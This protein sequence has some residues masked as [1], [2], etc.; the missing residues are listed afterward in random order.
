MGFLERLFGGKRARAI[1]AYQ[2]GAFSLQR[3]ELGHAWVCFLGAAQDG[4]PEAN[5]QL[6]VMRLQGQGLPVDFAEA[7]RWFTVAAE[8]GVP[9][10][11]HN[12]AILYQEG[13]G[14]V[15]NIETAALW[16]RRAADQGSTRAQ[17]KLSDMYAKG[18]GVPMDK[19]E[20]KRLY[21]LATGRD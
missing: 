7:V 11:Q 10:A 17:I 6:G 2:A 9:E 3:G 13:K 19:A 14:V 20:S 18:E 21:A 12:L 15:R 5:Y 8:Q 16:Y 4:L 1:E